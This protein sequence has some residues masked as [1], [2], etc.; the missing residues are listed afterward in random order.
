MKILFDPSV[1]KYLKE[2][3]EILYQKEYFGFEEDAIRYID[4]L[5]DS[6]YETLPNRVHKPAPPYFNRYGKKLLYATFKKNDHTH[7]YVFFH[8]ENDIYLIRYISNNHMI[9]QHL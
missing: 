4:A 3:S 6:I 5:I 7:W 2:V 8:Y 9:A 1:R